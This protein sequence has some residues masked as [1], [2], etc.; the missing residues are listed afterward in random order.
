MF[1][2]AWNRKVCTIAA[3][4]KRI[5]IH[6]NIDYEN[7]CNNKRNKKTLAEKY[8]Q[9]QSP[10]KSIFEVLLIIF[11]KCVRLLLLVPLVSCFSFLSHAETAFTQ[12]AIIWRTIWI[13]AQY[14]HALANILFESGGRY[15][16]V[17]K[18][19]P[20]VFVCWRDVILSC[21]Q[22]SFYSAPNCTEL[23]AVN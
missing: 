4:D 15:C 22:L 14:T 5:R 21:F 17:W 10:L 2:G 16:I 12:N 13:N 7:N 9:Q 1:D 20:C 19:N 3:D 8:E 11:A 18:K 6:E 23:I